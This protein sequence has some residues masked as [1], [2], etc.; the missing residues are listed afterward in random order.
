MEG[1][2]VAAAIEE[3]I[4][5]HHDAFSVELLGE[6]GSGLPLERIN[7]LINQG[8]LRKEQ[9]TG[10]TVGT[11]DV[12]ETAQRISHVMN[13]STDTERKNRRKLSLDEWK[14]LIDL[15]RQAGARVGSAETVPLPDPPPTPTTKID[16]SGQLQFVREPVDYT[17]A[18]KASYRQAI[19]RAGEFARGLGNRVSQDVKQNIVEVWDGT[20]IQLEADPKLRQEMQTV[21]REKVSEAV[22]KRQSAKKLASELGNA[23][24]DWARDW[25]RIARTELQATYNEGTVIEAIEIYGPEA[26]VARIPE[27]DACEHCLRLFLDE[28]NL[29]II[30]QVADLLSRG[31]NVG[32]KREQWQATMFPIHPWCRCDTQIVPPGLRFDKDGL[33]VPEGE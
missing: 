9:K 31:T 18:E 6:E 14:K 29:P 12:V 10:L 8:Y 13:T 1:I 16:A 15:S 3:A 23:T 11:M 27:S 20:K 28:D 4:T 2:E 21:I 19:K 24:E 7:Q 32:R 5:T 17:Q 22:A 30:F 25:G 33:F 26:R